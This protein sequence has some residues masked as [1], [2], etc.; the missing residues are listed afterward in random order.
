MLLGSI[1]ETA[2][3]AEHIATNPVRSVRKARPPHRE[4]VRPLAPATVEARRLWLLINDDKAIGGFRAKVD[5]LRKEWHTVLR[6]HPETKSLRYVS[7][8]QEIPVH[9]EELSLGNG[10]TEYTYSV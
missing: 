6:M 2:C 5:I 7:E 8:E 9:T 10:P 1:L 3:E 4:E